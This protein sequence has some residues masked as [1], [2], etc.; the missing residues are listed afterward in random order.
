MFVTLLGVVVGIGSARG[1]GAD[2]VCERSPGLVRRTVV[3][4]GLRRSYLVAAPPTTTATAP[5]TVRPPILLAFHGYSTS[6]AILASTSGLAP[7]ATEAGFVTVFPDGTG[8]PRRWAIPGRLPGPDDA[9]FVDALI[10]DVARRSCADAGRVYAAGFSNGA[11]FVGHLACVRPAA[12]RGFGLVGGAGLAPAC[13]AQ[14][15]APT[16]PAVLVPGGAD[17]VVRMA[18]GPVL[19]GALQAEPFVVSADRWRASAA[20]RRVV[21]RMVPGW[22]H[23][24]PS[25]ATRE[26]VATFAA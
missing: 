5:T 16:A 17:A 23:R 15:A 20:D 22:G 6:G 3:A 21:V 19:G 2:Q 10:A 4:G 9:A 8:A 24:W 25:L 1:A 14:Q 13:G 18:G 12:F 26:I 11:A 7:A